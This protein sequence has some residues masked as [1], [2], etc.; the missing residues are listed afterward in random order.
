MTKE[1]L[2]YVEN[3]HR[4]EKYALKLVVSHDFETLAGSI[5]ACLDNTSVEF[6]PYYTN[7]NRY[8]YEE[9]FKDE[10]VKS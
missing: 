7:L 1:D 3:K 2:Q 8:I 6:F 10:I 9:N 4:G 5:P